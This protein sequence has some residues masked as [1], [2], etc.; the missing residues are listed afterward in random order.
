MNVILM[1]A[2][3]LGITGLAIGIFL[4][5]ASKKFEVVIDP[6]IEEVTKNLPGAN[7]GACGF[8]GCAGYGDAI[9]TQGVDITLC[10]PG[11]S[12]TAKKVGD[13]MGLT[14][15]VS[16][17]K[18]VAKLLCQG[19]HGNTTEKYEFTGSLGTC[20]SVA[21]YAGGNK[22]CMHA[23]V[24]FGDCIKVCPVDAIKST[25]DGLVTI[26]EDIC[27]SCGKCV[28]Q[29]PKKVLKMLPQNK[30][31]TVRC[32]S[33]EKGPTARRGCKVACIACGICARNCPEQAITVEKNLAVI[34]PEKCTSCGLCVEKC[35]SKAITMS[36]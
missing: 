34:N 35:P 15:E 21:N 10:S 17:E 19:K 14:A 25:G 23:C 26:D 7:C 8:P 28:G 16:D 4:A 32:S 36:N 30:K 24:G 5:F 9:V 6:K 20:A 12:T 31:I 22:S 13:I 2:I 18:K 27:I 1:P 33:Q 11:G 3:I 29:C